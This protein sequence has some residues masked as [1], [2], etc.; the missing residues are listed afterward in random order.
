MSGG[1]TTTTGGGPR[2]WAR[3]LGLGVRFAVGGG[4]EGWIRTLL[5]ALGVGLGVALL[6]AASSLPAIQAHRAE[7]RLAAAVTSSDRAL[8]P[9]EATLVAADLRTLFRGRPLTGLMLRPDGPKA[10]TPPGVDALP[11]PGE[12]VLS[13]ALREL[14]ADPGSA[15]LRER[16]PYKDA[17][18]IGPAGLIGPDDLTYYL[19]SA[20]LTP[21]TGGHR[22]AGFGLPGKSEPLDPVLLALIIVACVV[23]LMPVAIFIA[24]AVRFGGERRDRRLAALRLI[25]A[26]ARMTRRTA[27]GEALFGALLGLLVGAALFL[28]GRQLTAGITF[29]NVNA[30]PSDVTPDPWLAALIV[31]AVPLSAVVVTLLA[32]RR[33]SIEPLGVARSTRGRRRRL[34]WRLPFPPAGL[35]LVFANGRVG[36]GSSTVNPYLIAGGATLFLLGVTLLLPWAVDAAV[37]RFRGGPVPWQ[38]AVRR[39]QLSGGTAAR[40]VS[41]ITVAV[42]GAIALQLLFTAIQSD[43]MKVTGQDAKRAQLQV[44]LPTHD[45]GTIRKMTAEFRRTPGVRGVIATIEASANRPGPLRKGEPFV[46][47][48]SV[49]VGDC[50]TLGELA[51]TGPCKDG[52]VFIVRDHTGQVEDSYIGKTARP[53][54]TV[55]FAWSDRAGRTPPR[56]RLW[57]LPEN[58]R[59]VESRPDPMGVSSFGIFATPGALDAKLLDDPQGRAMIKIDPHFPDAVEHARNTAARIDPLTSVR[60]LQNVERD[61]QY[62]SVRTGLLV[63]ATATL[64]LIAASMLVTMLEQLRERRRLLSVLVAFGTRRATLAWSVLWQTAV[65]VTLGLG[66][67][68]AGGIGL[69]LALLRMAGKTGFAWSAVWP[70]TAAG[71]ALVL[72]V[73]LLSLPP[74]WRMMRPDGLR[75]E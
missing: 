64:V 50:A 72:V 21:D 62:T 22:V 16:L 25:G 42:A 75:T 10:P 49:T 6:L 39:L 28:A 71:G 17:G 70:L 8:P 30:F 18:T 4:R 19:G 47:S 66:L 26:D 46:P 12:M 9:T 7:R 23:L 27:A 44:S 5:T 35:A 55:D 68:V 40:A 3:D 54:A 51:R 58:A 53:G 73:T 14:L 37:A 32:L 34:W 15:L 20:T 67:A 45:I 48:T 33:V 41:G 31:C 59:T 57:T 36:G 11:K 24:T 13:P 38:L 56:P 61:N 65:P 74:L 1:T 63:A 2:G 43:F 69:G 60:A 52:D 29:W